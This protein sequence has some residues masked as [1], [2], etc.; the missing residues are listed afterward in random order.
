M[1][2]TLAVNAMLLGAATFYTGGFKPQGAVPWLAAY[3]ALGPHAWLRRQFQRALFL[4]GAREPTITV[5]T[6]A[7]AGTLSSLGAIMLTGCT[8]QAYRAGVPI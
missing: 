8:N 1:V 5:C 3:A 6:F 4:A 7:L 2:W